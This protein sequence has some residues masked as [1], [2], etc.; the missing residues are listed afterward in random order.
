MPGAYVLV[1]ALPAAL[2][3]DL[4]RRA[5]AV[6][7]PGRY[8]YAGSAYGPGGL[9]ARLARHMA[10][11]KGVHWHVDRLTE[12]G[13]VSGAWIVPFGRECALVAGLAFLPLPVPGFGSTDCR[14]CK[15]HLLEWTAG[16][17]LPL[18]QPPIP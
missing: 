3:V 7:P 15:S 8:L 11:G 4:P 12:A 10:S 13:Q 18:R 17:E 2:P 1:I 6:L 9:R 14:C 16:V 5:P